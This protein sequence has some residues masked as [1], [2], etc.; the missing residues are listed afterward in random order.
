M[1]RRDL[2]FLPARQPEASAD[3]S[4]LEHD[5]Q[6]LE[7]VVEKRRARE[8]EVHAHDLPVRRVDV[9]RADDA[10]LFVVFR[11]N[12]DL[13][14]VDALCARA[15]REAVGQ[16]E[17]VLAKPG[18]R[19]RMRH[20]AHLVALADANDVGK[21]V[22]DDAQMVAVIRDVRRQEQRVAA[23][24][25][26]LLALVG[27][28]PVDF[29]LQLVGFDDLGRRGKAFAKLREEGHVAVR[30]GLVVREAGVGELLGAP[31]RGAV[32]QRRAARIVPRLRVDRP[33][34]EGLNTT[35]N[36]H[37]AAARP[38]AARNRR[39]IGEYRGAFLPEQPAA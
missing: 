17:V 7:R 1:P 10:R 3:E 6:L 30:A 32:D 27:R 11:A 9:D 37:A 13:V 36:T 33:P 19:Q 15:D 5:R 20:V 31:L 39:M 26:A 12:L 21:V 23:A 24:D 34:G 14:D 29:Q 28:V 38:R 22:L 18:R 25:D 16:R 2:D 4:V 35:T 8:A